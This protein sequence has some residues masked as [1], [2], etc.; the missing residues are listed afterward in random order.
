[1]HR[2]VRSTALLIVLLTAVAAC[3]KKA[4]PA[5]QAQAAAVTAQR[6]ENADKEPGQTRDDGF[7]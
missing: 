7:C 4:P 1:M 2:A 3:T 6:M 5:T